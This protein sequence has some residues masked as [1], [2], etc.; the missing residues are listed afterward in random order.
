[1]LE[2]AE[3][4][5]SELEDLMRHA[6]KPYVRRKATALWNLAQ[7][8]TI[9]QVAQFLD[10][11]PSRVSAWKAGYL[12]MGIESFLVRPGRGRPRQAESVEIES[13]LRQSPRNFGLP[14][15]RWS[16]SALAETVPSLKGFTPSGVWRALRRC[17]FSY[18][19]G[20]PLIYS[21]DPAYVQKRGS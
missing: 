17:G 18:K 13:Y 2:L 20:Q 19:R 9:A 5:I 6:P 7:G 8:R 11:S 15:T 14:L 21:P 12:D 10:T 4:Q 1:M 3:Q 16:L